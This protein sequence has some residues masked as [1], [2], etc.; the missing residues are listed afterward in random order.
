MYALKKISRTEDRRFSAADVPRRPQ[1]PTAA[2][3]L[4]DRELPTG[5]KKKYYN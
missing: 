5:G 1:R 2:D 4:L 3:S